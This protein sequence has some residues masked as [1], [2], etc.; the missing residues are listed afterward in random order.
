LGSNKVKLSKVGSN[1][2]VPDPMGARPTKSYLKLIFNF[3]LN[4]YL[5]SNGIEFTLKN[6]HTNLVLRSK[7]DFWQV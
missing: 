4:S 3:F 2:I 5:P 7:A 1:A 6:F